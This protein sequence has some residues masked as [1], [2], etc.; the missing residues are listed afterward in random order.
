MHI[1]LKPATDR[2][3]AC[4]RCHGPLTTVFIQGHEQC[5]VRKIN[6]IECCSGEVCQLSASAAKPLPQE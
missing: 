4:T 3:T 5:L 6:I 1:D 2:H